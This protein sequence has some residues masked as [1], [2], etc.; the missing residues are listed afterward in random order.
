MKYNISSKSYQQRVMCL[1]TKKTSAHPV[2]LLPLATEFTAVVAL[3]L[4]DEK[5]K[6]MDSSSN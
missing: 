5:R 1:Y 6:N 3:D 4:K 2:V